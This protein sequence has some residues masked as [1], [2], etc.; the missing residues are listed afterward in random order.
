MHD[1]LLGHSNFYFCFPSSE[2]AENL[3]SLQVKKTK[4][5][6]KYLEHEPKRHKSNNTMFL[7]G[8]VKRNSMFYLNCGVHFA[9]KPDKNTKNQTHILGRLKSIVQYL[10]E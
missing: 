3:P 2:V 5:P 7:I 6:E 1:G 9:I 10:L 4:P 8:P